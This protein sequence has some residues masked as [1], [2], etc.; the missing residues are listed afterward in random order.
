[1][2][3]HTIVLL[4]AHE[5]YQQIEYGVTAEILKSE[6]V[7]VITASN[8]LGYATAKDTSSTSIDMT[9]DQINPTLYDGLFII[10][11]PGALDSLN[12]PLVHGLL[13]QMMALDKPY[14]AICISSRI[15]AQAHVLAGKKA[16]G[17][18][19]D[20]A[21]EEIFKDHGVIYSK[22]PVVTDGK[23][24]TATGPDAAQE[25][26]QAILQVLS[27]QSS[28]HVE[29]LPYKDPTILSE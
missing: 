15:L 7:Q 21:L 13:E 22:E 16:T 9:I 11:G 17:W 20:G 14:G 12:T 3:K 23:V 27:K 18:D 26:A 29:P 8:Q 5:G 28:P 6:N 4:I 10:G 19:E 25:F 24:V 2:A 1:M